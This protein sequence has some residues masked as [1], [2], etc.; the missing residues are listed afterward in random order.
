MKKIFI[1]LIIIT[2]FLNSTCYAEEMSTIKEPTMNSTQIQQAKNILKPNF[3]K[4]LQNAERDFKFVLT[5]Q[6]LHNKQP[7]TLY[8]FEPNESI[9]LEQQHVSLL[10]NDTTKNLQGLVRLLPKYQSSSQQVSKE[11]ALQI[12]LNFLKDYAPDLLENYNNNWINTHNETIIVDG[13][14]NTLT[15]MKVKCRDLNT[16]LYFWTIIGPDQTVMVFER[17]I[18]WDFIRAGRQTQKWLHDS[19][20]AKHL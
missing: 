15:G 5:K 14:K 13:K 12:T 17:D 16:G 19:W 4:L 3:Q 11:I 2:S 8:R 20:L 6:G 18:D 1:S 7:V 10:I 9:H